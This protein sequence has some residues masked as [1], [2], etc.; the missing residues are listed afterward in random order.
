MLNLKVLEL[1][2]NEPVGSNLNF[3]LLA[4][5]LAILLVDFKKKVVQH[6]DY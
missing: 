2:F 1:K 6:E 3:C 4:R 5:S